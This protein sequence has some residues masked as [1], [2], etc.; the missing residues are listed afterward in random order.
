MSEKNFQ[1]QRT[2]K[3]FHSS[4]KSARQYFEIIKSPDGSMLYACG[5]SQPYLIWP[6]KLNKMFRNSMKLEEISTLPDSVYFIHRF[7]EDAVPGW[8]G[9]RLRYNIYFI[10]VQDVLSDAIVFTYTQIFFHWPSHIWMVT[11]SGSVYF[12]SSLVPGMNSYS[13]RTEGDGMEINICID[14][15]RNL[16]QAR[17]V[18]A[19][20]FPN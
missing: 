7:M 20:S 17:F 18:T 19:D 13:D 1:G 14:I 2:H 15:S 4:K 3:D 12:S 16:Q 10:P 8:R 5:G 11:D 9:T 6:K